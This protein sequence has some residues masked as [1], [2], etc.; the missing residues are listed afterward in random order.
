MMNIKRALIAALLLTLMPFTG[1][2]AMGEAA[3]LRLDFVD[4]RDYP[5]V[6]LRLSAWDANGLPLEGL[7]RENF[8]LQ[9]DGG[10]QIRPDDVQADINAA[11]RVGLVIDVSESMQ[12]Q[13]LDDA[14]AAAARFLDHLD[15]GDQGALVAFSDLVN[16]DPQVMDGVR[17]LGFSTD[18]TQMYNAVEKLQAGGSTHLYNALSKGLKSFPERQVGHSAILLLTDGKNEPAD[19][20]DLEEPLRLAREK[21]IPI[22]IIGLGNKIDEAYLQRL[23]SESGGMLRIAPRSS[24]LAS[25]FND[26]ATLLKTQYVLS[27]TSHLPADGQM[28]DISITL[29]TQG[30]AATAQI[31]LGPLPL[32]ATKAP[33]SPALPS[34][35]HTASVTSTAVPPSPTPVPAPPPQEGSS[36]LLG[37]VI[38]LILTA[39]V[40]WRVTR[41]AKSVPSYCAAC[42]A[43]VPGAADVCQVCGGTNFLA[44]PKI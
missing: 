6:T 13:P 7:S 17:E 32:I 23:A 2:G 22:F 8:I 40:I 25:L 15:Q 24:E 9:E 29:N 37:V 11:L 19:E 20:G 34:P 42:G 21:N 18:L 27:Y 5:A 28:H 16:T 4:Y 41:R 31:K 30:S 12:G 10:T 39:S 1:A 35:T 44:K 14:R 33:T 26:M 38:G 3:S 36:L 43:Q